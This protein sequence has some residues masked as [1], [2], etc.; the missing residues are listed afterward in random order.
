MGLETVMLTRRAVLAGL[1]SVPLGGWRVR[2]RLLD[3]NARAV[4]EGWAKLPL[5]ERIV[6][7]G[8]FFLGT[9]YVGGTLDTRPGAEECTVVFDG[10]DCVTFVELS[11]GLAQVLGREHRG[12]TRGA[13]RTE[14]ERMRYRGGRRDG[15][16]SRLHYTTDWLADNASRGVIQLPLDKHP[17]RSAWARVI[18][19]M[20]THPEAYPALKG[21]TDLRAAIRV[22]EREMGSRKLSWV[23]RS[24]VGTL[25]SSLRSGDM[26]AFA[27]DVPGLDCSHVGLV[28]REG[29]GARILHA[30]SAK[31]QVVLDAPIAEY[32]GRS[33]HCTGVFVARLA[34]KAT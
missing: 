9:P 28:A 30:S 14:I 18:D 32:V 15:Y 24:R 33:A 22:V 29:G 2:D 12:V 26:V 13:L 5:G 7:S 4:S 3:F 23:E 27:T 6:H 21:Q 34:H 25:E 8:S 1:M 20:S 16:V 10:L 19:Y 17:D 31:A 11:F